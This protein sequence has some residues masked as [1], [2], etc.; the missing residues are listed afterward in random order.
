MI[1]DDIPS[2]LPSSAYTSQQDRSSK[3]PLSSE[4]LLM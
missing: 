2:L 1:E 3:G 4:S